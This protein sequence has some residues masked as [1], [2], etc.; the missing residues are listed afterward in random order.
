MR[1]SLLALT[2]LALSIGAPALAQTKDSAATGAQQQA[3]FTLAPLPYAYE[4]LSPVIDVETMRIHH[5]LSRPSN[6]IAA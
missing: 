6:R 2:V 5:G 3:A 4:A 1:P